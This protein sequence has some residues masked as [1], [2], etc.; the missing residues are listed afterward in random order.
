LEQ[1]LIT[2]FIPVLNNVPFLGQKLADDW[3][4]TFRLSPAYIGFGMIVN[5]SINA[6]ILLGV[7][8]GW[9][10]LSPLAHHQGWAPAHP[11]DWDSGAQGWIIWV[12]M[13]LLLGDSLVGL[14]WLTF[15]PIIQK[16]Y[17]RRQRTKFHT[18]SADERTSLLG[19]QAPGSLEPVNDPS[20][21][22]KKADKRIDDPWP[23]QSIIGLRFNA[24]LFA[25]V[26]IACVVSLLFVFSKN[27]PWQAILSALVIGPVASFLSM[28]CYG[29]VDTAGLIAISRYDLARHGIV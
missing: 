18:S 4:W 14:A 16:Y 3:A 2:Y 11:R 27:I 1:T 8:V 6:S 19:R 22:T 15:R 21:G 24:S 7:I 12:G 10:V 23:A 5:P 25:C 13:G 28:R 20:L 9:G 17:Y 29:Q 26:N